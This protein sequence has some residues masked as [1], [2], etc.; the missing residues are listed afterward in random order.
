MYRVWVWLSYVSELDDD[1]LDE[2]K[3]LADNHLSAYSVDELFAMQ[4]CRPFLGDIIRW[5]YHLGNGLAGHQE[6]VL[7]GH[8]CTFPRLLPSCDANALHAQMA[9]SFSLL[10]HLLS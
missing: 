5:S 7:Q 9:L 10:S 3:Q 2:A 6:P 1:E 8:M 4:Q